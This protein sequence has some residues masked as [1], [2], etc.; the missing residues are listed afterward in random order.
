[1]T[2]EHSDDEAHSRSDASSHSMGNIADT[3]MD[4]GASGTSSAEN[5]R[6][7]REKRGDGASPQPPPP[8]SPAAAKKKRTRTLTTPHQSAVLHALLAQSR[9]PTTAMREEVGRSIGLSARKVQV[10]FQNQRQK[11]R[12]PRNQGSAAPARPPQYGGFPNAPAPS[13]APS[14]LIPSSLPPDRGQL[15]FHVAPTPFIQFNVNREYSS[16]ETVFASSVSGT[17]PNPNPTSGGS[18]LSGPGVPG[19]S[20]FASRFPPIP[21]PL[22]PPPPPPP[23]P[24]LVD[25]SQ[26]Q[27]PRDTAYSSARHAPS[28]DFTF[29]HPFPPLQVP[30][31]GGY[32]GQSQYPHLPRPLTVFDHRHHLGDHSSSEPRPQQKAF[33]SS[34]SSSRS[35]TPG[36]TSF[37]VP[38]GR[39]DST[40]DLPRLQIPPLHV[41]DSSHGQPVQQQRSAVRYSTPSP[42]QRPQDPVRFSQPSEL[43]L[44]SNTAASGPS[45]GG[46]SPH[47]PS[48]VKRFD[49]VREAASECSGSQGSTYSPTPPPRLDT[50]HI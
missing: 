7:V 34:R 32:S 33:A 43:A 5:T 6:Q 24:L 38:R 3:E 22:L 4:V 29:S 19:T 15:P 12:R 48:R 49:P 18:L 2:Q 50:P 17:S 35:Q 44:V 11:A 27:P 46:E 1:M 39:L 8:P 42:P 13:S 40:R 16:H 21:Q 14:S 28:G 47:G 41:P 9:F 30:K 31:T 45:R 25:P 36:T 10:W 26:S 23:P 20:S 37:L